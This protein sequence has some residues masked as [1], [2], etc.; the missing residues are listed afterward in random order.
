M[1]LDLRNSDEFCAPVSNAGVTL[2]R[3]VAQGVGPQTTFPC[4]DQATPEKRSTS[5]CCWTSSARDPQEF[6]GTPPVRFSVDLLEQVITAL[7]RR[8]FPEKTPSEAD[9]WKW[10]HCQISMVESPKRP[11]NVDLIS[12]DFAG[13]V[14]A[15]EVNQAA[16]IPAIEHVVAQ[17]VD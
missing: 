4:P 7:E 3:T 12:P 6:R 5:V 9:A 10:L 16:S 8:A 2:S 14:I 1:R 15:M 13:E 17:I 11:R